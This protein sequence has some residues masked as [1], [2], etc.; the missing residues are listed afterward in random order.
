VLHPAKIK[1]LIIRMKKILNN[2]RLLQ[3]RCFAE[4]VSFFILR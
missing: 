1:E 3:K 4:A 2:C